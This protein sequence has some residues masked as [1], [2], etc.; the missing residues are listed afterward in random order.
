MPPQE[1]LRDAEPNRGRQ[2]RASDASQRR[3]TERRDLWRDLDESSII[4]VE[5]IGAIGTWGGIGWLVDHWLDTMPWLFGTGVLVGFAAGL[6]L[7]WLRTGERPEPV[8]PSGVARP[9]GHD[10]EG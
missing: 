2:D 9:G 5:L 7:V 6:Y 1:P 3:D 4:S 8:A 10:D